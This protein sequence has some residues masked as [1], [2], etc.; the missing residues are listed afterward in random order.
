M[1]ATVKPPRLTAEETSAVLFDYR[2]VRDWLLYVAH[3][4]GRHPFVAVTSMLL[5]GG[6][7]LV[8]AAGLPRSYE[9]KTRLLSNQALLS[10][11]NPYGGP[12]DELPAIAARE[13]I[14]SYDSLQKIVEQLGLVAS[15]Q[16]SRTPLFRFSDEVQQKLGG[17]WSDSD[18]AD[19]M[20]G[21]LEKRMKV[22]AEK[23]TIEIS[24]VWSHP[25]VARQIVEV[26]SQNFLETRH[27]TE[28]A[29]KSE[30][31]AVLAGFQKQ[32]DE[33]TER[34]FANLKRVSDERTRAL[35]NVVAA[36]APKAPELPAKPTEADLARTEARA[37]E[38][39]QLKFQLRSRQRSI[40]DLE[41]WRT[42]SL[43]D[44]RTQLE[45]QKLV[46]RPSHPVILQLEN[47][48]DTVQRDS[49]QLQALRREEEALARQLETKGGGAQPQTSDFLLMDARRFPFLWPP[50]DPHISDALDRE[51][52]RDPALLMAQDAL[53]QALG[54]AQE[55]RGRVD[56]AK[57][58]LDSSRASYKYSFSVVAPPQTPRRPVSPNVPLLIFCGMLA[59]LLVAML[60]CTAID[61][62]RGRMVEAWQIHRTLR[63]PVLSSV[64]L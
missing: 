4:V 12:G 16:K 52:A 5:V 48:I 3:S 19:M 57:I 33:E 32:L 55:L 38:L 64:R 35:R 44:L 24:V 7:A 50:P 25:F 43:G 30:T 20:I 62:W 14:L 26:A 15:W 1:S 42:R 18:R 13:K 41:D 21:T 8:A 28:V 56:Q 23:G 9:V 49:P 22:K 61:V 17:R 34:A 31:I 10:A 36:N 2:L 37:A 45:Q 46:Y 59:G 6:V 60:A 47:R 58:E 39:Q 63:M 40:Q 53:R 11:P 54:R 27:V 29:T 51:L